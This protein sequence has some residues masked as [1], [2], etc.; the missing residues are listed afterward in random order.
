MTEF[1]L[2]ADHVVTP[3]GVLD[4]GRVV[5]RDGRILAVNAEPDGAG[6]NG[7][8]A[9]AADGERL[10]GWLVPG[11]VDTHGHGGGGADFATTDP[12]EARRAVA[13]H[14]GHGTTT[15]L[16]SLVTASI[17][18]L[19][20]QL[21]TLAPLVAAG[22]LAGV[23]LEGPFLSPDHR[24]AHDQALLCHPRHDLVDRLLDAGDGTIR[25]VT[26]APELP[27]GI[28]AIERLVE[29]GVVAAFGHSDAD[30]TVLRDAIEAGASVA[31][32]LFNAMRPI[33]HREPGPVPRLLTDQR[34]TVE[35]IC[36]GFHLHPDVIAMAIATAG[37]ERVAL[38]TDAMLAAGAA[39]GRYRLG[40]LAVEVTDGQARLVEPDGTL[41]SIA[42]STLT[43]GDAVALVV[44]LG[45]S[46]PDAALMSA[47]TPARRHGLLD[48][49]A[50]EAGRRADFCLVDDQ[51]RLLRVM[52]AGVWV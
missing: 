15:H 3:G 49:G 46:I 16:A 9:E 14:R 38:V 10:S 25:M 41:G 13:F 35:L 5:V 40:S 50:V 19:L 36:D 34:V 28:A 2:S 18:T 21:R 52:Q 23:H 11:Y 26:L 33:H 45:I 12:D 43:M 4:R 32:H 7:G 39:D 48:V 30:E 31:T 17:D 1:V 51:G 42:G 47:T 6:A 20:R 24:G 27:G 37:P 44:G 29:A 22:E 8:A